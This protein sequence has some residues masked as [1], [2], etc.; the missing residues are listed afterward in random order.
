V[1]KGTTVHDEIDWPLCDLDRADLTRKK[2][3]M[4]IEHIRVQKVD[5]G[6]CS[7]PKREAL[8]E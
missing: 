8:V 6:Q 2:R 7:L 3:K 4:W 5:L 1:R